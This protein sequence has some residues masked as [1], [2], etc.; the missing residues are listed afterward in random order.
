MEQFR[1]SASTSLPNVSYSSGDFCLV[2][3][4]VQD[5][6]SIRIWRNSQLEVLRQT[7]QISPE[8][9]SHYFSE[10]FA[11]TATSAKPA[12]VLYS[13]TLRNGNLAAYGG[14]VHVNWASGTAELSFLASKEIA[15]VQ[16]LYDKVFG[17]FLE[18]IEK[19]AFIDLGLKLLFT[20]TFPFRVGHMRI[21]ESYGYQTNCPGLGELHDERFSPTSVYHG[22]AT[23]LRRDA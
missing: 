16:P 13:L 5:I 18:L 12:S 4:R 3:I 9:Q 20:E 19:V 10:Y 14:L 23:H 22:K 2:P 17:A 11:N 8:Q 6:E 7:S 1:A 15:D 21:L